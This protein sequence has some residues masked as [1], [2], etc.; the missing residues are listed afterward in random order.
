MVTLVL[1]S[2]RKREQKAALSNT[3]FF[4]DR[5]ANIVI[6]F[7]FLFFPFAALKLT[8]RT[9]TTAFDTKIKIK[10]LQE[11]CAEALKLV[12]EWRLVDPEVRKNLD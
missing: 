11:E 8:Q 2:K 4:P 6:F 9:S 5:I 1:I 10:V 7:P 3:D 12:K